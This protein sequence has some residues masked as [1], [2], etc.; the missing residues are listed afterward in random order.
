MLGTIRTFLFLF[1]VLAFFGMTSDARSAGV[2]DELTKSDASPLLEFGEDRYTVSAWIKTTSKGGPILTIGPLDGNWET[3]CKCL[4]LAE[5]GRIKINVA[6]AGNDHGG[7]VLNDGKWHHI[8]MPSF[9][10]WRFYIDGEQSFLYI[11]DGVPDPGS[12]RNP[13][14]GGP[15]CVMKIGQ[16]V[17]DFPNDGQRQFVGQIDNVRIYDR[18]LKKEEIAE[19]YKGRTEFPDA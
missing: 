12:E 3:G 10:Q 17:N 19:L 11:I 8:V 9:Q 7:P 6:G 4:Y 1:A 2:E 18:M 14:K 16:G 13:I 5:D 15:G